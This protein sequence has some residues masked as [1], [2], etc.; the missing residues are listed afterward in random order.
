MDIK[1]QNDEQLNI[2]GQANINIGEK[3]IIDKE[4]I[5]FTDTERL[6]LLN[7]KYLS[8]LEIFDYPSNYKDPNDGNITSYVINQKSIKSCD[9]M[10]CCHEPS[11]NAT[12]KISINGVQEY[13]DV[14][15]RIRAHSH[16]YVGR[17]DSTNQRLNVR[18]V[19]DSNKRKW[20]DD[21][22]IT[23]G[24]DDVFMKL[25]EFWWKCEELQEDV[26]KVSFTMDS[27]Y[28]DNTWNHWEGNSFIGVYGMGMVKTSNEDTEYRMASSWNIYSSAMTYIV[29]KYDNKSIFLTY[30]MYKM[31]VMLLYGW[32]GT[33]NVGDIVGNG[34]IN[35]TYFSYG[36]CDTKGM[37]DTSIEEDGNDVPINTW[38]IEDLWGIGCQYIYNLFEE[39][40]D[41]TRYIVLR[42]YNNLNN[43]VKLIEKPDIQT[44]YDY[45]HIK[46]LILGL[47]FDIIFKEAKI[48]QLYNIEKEGFC[49]YHKIGKNLSEDRYM[50]AISGS[51]PNT[52]NIKLGNISLLNYTKEWISNER[53]FNPHVGTTNVTRLCYIGNYNIVEDLDNPS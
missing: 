44:N 37:T 38:G 31:L 28:T 39:K 21:S 18:Q 12:E 35:S 9:C 49:S 42:D 25:P 13:K 20:T 32:Y 8:L 52:Q 23:I 4:V 33:T 43:I 5:C 47:N 36:Y 14:I 6:Q 15:A 45:L 48:K 16:I 11:T 27:S 40:I 17:W 22:D 19:S 1:L 29:K 51:L 7:D 3:V 34:Y 30:E 41:D 10:I 24:T 2:S 26:Y 50:A 46:K 53:G